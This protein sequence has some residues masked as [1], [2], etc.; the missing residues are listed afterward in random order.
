MSTTDLIARWAVALQ[1]RQ[2]QLDDLYSRVYEACLKAA[3]HFEEQ[4]KKTIRDFKF[5]QGSLVL[6]RHSQYDKSLNRKMCP[7]YLGPLVVVSRN[8]GGAY[9]LAKLDGSVLDR[10]LTAFRVIPYFARQSVLLPTSALDAGLEV[11]QRLK[12]STSQ[13]DDK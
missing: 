6:I 13:G 1:K 5:Q 7:H 9:I 11:L 8:W 10:P 4:H 12:N 2:E 3:S